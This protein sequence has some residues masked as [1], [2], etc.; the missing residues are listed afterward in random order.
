VPENLSNPSYP[1]SPRK[2]HNTEQPILYP[3]TDFV[4]RTFL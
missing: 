4:N 1:N 3:E 2:T